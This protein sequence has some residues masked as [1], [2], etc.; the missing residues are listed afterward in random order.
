[1]MLD[2]G[3]VPEPVVFR[4]A[5]DLGKYPVMAALARVGHLVDPS[6]KEAWLVQATYQGRRMDWQQLLIESYGA[7]VNSSGGFRTT[8]LIEACRRLDDAVALYLIEQ[9]ADIDAHAPGKWGARAYA[10]RYREH[11][12]LTWARIARHELTRK[13]DKATRRRVV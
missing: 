9:G 12:P 8:P 6:Q 5:F 11:M 4:V 7:S 1:A 10:R 2:A 13:A 3:C